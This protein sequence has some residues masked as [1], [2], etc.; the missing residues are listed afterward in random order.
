VQGVTWKVD[1]A[2]ANDPA[3][4]VEEAVSAA[5]ASSPRASRRLI[6]AKSFGCFALPWAKRER[7]PGI[8]LTPVM[9]SDVVRRE[10]SDATPYDLVIGG[11]A[12]DLWQP[13]SL[14]GTRA[15]LLTVP[16]ADHSLTV[17]AGWRASRSAQS[18]VF[19]AISTHLDTHMPS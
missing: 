6:V 9:T 3:P 2:A 19:D 18:G 5:F 16:D 1:D 7:I 14:D 17:R 11:D 13:R 10:L 8:W 4:F 15:R 12:D